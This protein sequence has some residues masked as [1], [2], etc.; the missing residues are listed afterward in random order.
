MIKGDYDRLKEIAKYNVC[1]E[2][3]TPLEIAWHS[4]E[5]VWVLRC[6]HDHYPDAVTKQPSLTELWKQGEEIP[7]PIK[8]NIEKRQRRKAMTQ[9]KQ[10][11][12]VTFTGVPAADLGTG[13]ILSLE[14]VKALVDYAHKYHLDPARGHV[15]L[16]Y[17]KP[18]IT[19]DGYLYHANQSGIP[20]SLTGR[21]LTDDELKQRGYELNDY[22]YY[23][24]VKRHDTDQEF[25]GVGFI[26]RAE[27]EAKAKGKPDQARYPV[28]AEKP[29]QMV[30]K[31]AEWQAL[32][33]AF[34][35][36]ETEGT[37]NE[38]RD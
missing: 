10:S 8:S 31:R 4:E 25:E 9:G 7:E 3:K 15:V 28:V 19:I 2:H 26:T 12:A 17:S 5:K 29:G 23:A 18:Y 16:M 37:Q 1:A 33:R 32:R 6:G 20:Y 30:Q 35:I 22:G 34:P 36:G 21:P 14:V 24:K 38:S 13:E 11:T 27:I